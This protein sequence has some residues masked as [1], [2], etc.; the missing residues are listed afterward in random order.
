LHKILKT[1]KKQLYICL[2]FHA[3]W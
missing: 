1:V 2:V 3:S